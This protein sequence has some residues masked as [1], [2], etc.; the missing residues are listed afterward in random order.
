M[1]GSRWARWSPVGGILFVALYLIALALTSSPDSGK[2]DEK[3]LAHYAKASNRHQDIAAFFLIL[4]ASLAFVWFLSVLRKRLAASEGGP[5]AWTAA[6]FGSGFAS[7]A[8]WIAGF[9]LFTA[10]SLARADTDKFVLDPNTFRI[11]NDVGYAFWFSGTTVA[12]VIV[13]STAWLSLRNRVLP[14]WLTWLSFV[15]TLTMLVS[16]FFVPLLIFL[17]WVLVTSAIFLWRELRPA[18]VAAM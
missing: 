6:A 1:A 2:A 3:I 7:I 8:L 18:P 13:F 16:F 4:A 15:V 9:G 12:S 17:G 10:P 14:T 11:L 5:G